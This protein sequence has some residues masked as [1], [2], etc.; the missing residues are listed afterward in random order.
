MSVQM[1]LVVLMLRKL[2]RDRTRLY[3]RV[4]GEYN[5]KFVYPKI[6]AY[7]ESKATQTDQLDGTPIKTPIR[8]PFRKLQPRYDSP[9][10]MR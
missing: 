4:M 3:A 7:K 2:Q 6:F 8:T 9:L 1:Y 10:R 5:S